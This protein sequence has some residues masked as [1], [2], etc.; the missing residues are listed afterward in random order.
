[1]HIELVS[2]GAGVAALAIV[3]KLT[4]QRQRSWVERDLQRGDLSFLRDFA[5]FRNR[6][7]LSAAVDRLRERGFLAKN[8]RARTRMTMKGWLAILSD[9][10]LRDARKTA[11]VLGSRRQARALSAHH[12]RTTEFAGKVLSRC[13]I[14]KAPA[15]VAA[16][17][18]APPV[19]SHRMPM[20]DH[21]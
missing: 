1:M 10:L 7:P 8:A 15:N 2:I 14:N 5:F 9:T 3:A 18:V 13:E 12:Y 20:V 11:T 16:I 6:R 19:E 21:H 4:A 17:F